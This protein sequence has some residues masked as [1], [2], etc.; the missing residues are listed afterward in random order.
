MTQR[1]T[2]QVWKV[3]G[4]GIAAVAVVLAA[5]W[6][7]LSLVFP[8]KVTRQMEGYLLDPDG[9]PDSG[10]AVTLSFEGEWL[11]R[12]AQAICGEKQAAEYSGALT[13]RRD[14]TA[15]TVSLTAQPQGGASDG[16]RNV[17]CLSSQGASLGGPLT[18]LDCQADL[19]AQFH[20]E[21]GILVA[22]LTAPG[23]ETRL[24]VCA[25]GPMTEEQLAQICGRWT[26]LAE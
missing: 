2:N 24:L 5:L 15:E 23:G 1:K 25:E 13:V 16:W 9:G 3:L 20:E 6:V 21:D 10:Q 7:I 18:L 11:P 19:L 8:W 26:G 22:A 12:L 14:G 4:I 17:L